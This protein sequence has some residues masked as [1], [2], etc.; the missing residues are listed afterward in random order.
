MWDTHGSICCNCKTLP[1]TKNHI[2]IVCSDFL[3]LFCFNLILSNVQRKRTIPNFYLQDITLFF[4]V[5]QKL[6]KFIFVPKNVQNQY[7]RVKMYLIETPHCKL[8]QWES[9]LWSKIETNKFWSL[10]YKCFRFILFNPLTFCIIGHFSTP[11][12]IYLNVTKCS[13]LYTSDTSYKEIFC[14]IVHCFLAFL[15]KALTVWNF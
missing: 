10:F 8:L 7:K 4:M 9:K 12:K 5:S 15:Y 14:M 6:L 11:K 1:K 3:F 13:L 2:L